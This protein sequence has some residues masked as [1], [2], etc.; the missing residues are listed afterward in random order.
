MLI[1]SQVQLL[2][3]DYCEWLERQDEG[4]LHQV[5][6]F[7]LLRLFFL[8]IFSPLFLDHPQI[9]LCLGSEVSLSPAL[10]LSLLSNRPDELSVLRCKIVY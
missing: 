4:L 3:R 10:A 6:Q 9:R 5:E 1:V 8:L 2:S 7:L